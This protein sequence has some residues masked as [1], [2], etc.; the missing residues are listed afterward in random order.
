M[1][2]T[3]DHVA[4]V[5]RD[6]DAATAQ[7]S[8]LLGCSPVRRGPAG[9]VQ[10]AW[11]Q[12][13]NMALDLIAPGSAEADAGMQAKLAAAEG[14][15]AIAF[16]TPDLERSRHVFE[17]RGIS[18]TSAQGQ[19]S[20]PLAALATEATHGATLLLVEEIPGGMV[21]RPA[22]PAPVEVSAASIMW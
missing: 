11:F 20:R 2:T 14:L 21:S 19:H 9:G 18:S 7:Y 6:L 15:W 12:L 1:L 16:A 10:H 8:A 22:T 4:V 13:N 17:R 5:V 3:I